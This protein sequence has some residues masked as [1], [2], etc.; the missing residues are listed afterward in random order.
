MDTSFVD[1]RG[2]ISAVIFL[3]QCNFR[4]P[5]CHNHRL[6]LDPSG[7]QDLS[8]DWILRRLHGLR[9]WVDGVCITGGEPTLHDSLE[10]IVGEVRSR[11]FL[12]KLDTNGSRPEVLEALISMEMLDAVSMDVKAPLRPEA[13]TR[14]AGRSVPL[15]RILRSLQIL[16]Q[17]KLEVEFRTTVVPGLLEESDIYQIARILPRGIP[18]HLQGFRSES[19]LDPRL[20]SIRPFPQQ[21]LERMRAQVALIRFET[22]RHP[23]SLY[24]PQASPPPFLALEHWNQGL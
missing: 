15:H 3:G 1:W 5:Y 9:G 8:W 7:L 24:Q 12:V 21:E 13:Y 6:V 18:Y 4:C 19:T 2:K 17:A 22:D 14:C 10:T 20:R 11:D 16:E 23:P